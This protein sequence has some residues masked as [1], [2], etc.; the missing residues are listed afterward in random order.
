VAGIVFTRHA[1]DRMVLRGVS[2]RHVREIVGDPDWCEDAC[3]GRFKGIKR[4]GGREL[5]VIYKREK[6]R[7]VII[8][9]RVWRR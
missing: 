6:G 7:I 9:V 5:E 3:G 1:R 8:T 4:F 2:E